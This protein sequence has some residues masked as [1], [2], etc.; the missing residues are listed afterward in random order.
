MDRPWIKPED[1]KAYSDSQKVKARS[2][3]QLSV[4]IARAERYVIFHTHNKFDTADYAESIPDDVK[5]AVTLLAEAYA[6]Q[7]IIQKD[8]LLESE[9]FDD[10]SYTVKS[11]ANIAEEL[12][13]GVFLDEYILYPEKGKISMNLRKL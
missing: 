13:L 7:A 8:G 5:M 6:K 3:S 4:D 9:T 12:G 1:V 2:D 10:Y 11:D